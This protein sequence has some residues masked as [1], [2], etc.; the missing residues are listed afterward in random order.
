MQLKE[1]FDQLVLKL[2]PV[3]KRILFESVPDLSDNTLA[4]FNEMISRELNE[5]YELCWLIRSKDAKLPHNNN[6]TSINPKNRLKYAFFKRTSCAVICCNAMIEPVRNNQKTFFLTHGVPVKNVKSYNGVDAS[7]MDYLITPSEKLNK[8]MSDQLNID[9]SRCIAC[10]FPRNDVFYSKP[11]SLKDYFDKDYKKYIVWYPT[12]R[13]SKSGRVT[14]SKD[15]MP[16]LHDEN[17]AVELNEWAKKYDVLLIVKPH[18]AQNTDY[19]KKLDLS[20]IRLIDDTFFVDNRIS[21]YEFL[22]ACDS[23]ITDYSSVY[24]DYLLADKPIAVVWEDIEEYRKNPGFAIDIDYYMKAAFKI[25]DLD[26]FKEYIKIL[27]EKK[28]YLQKERS[29]ILL[30]S[31]MA[32]QGVSSGRLVDFILSVIEK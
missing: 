9:I 31:G 29:E 1:Y 10:G 12:Y 4:V 6:V 24:F 15:S 23:M 20:N 3:K 25:Y 18:F 16:I 13:Q 30:E 5:K 8:L 32:D 27:S 22:N 11:L 14:G 26:D 7:K 2:I 28:D 21:S 19:I 17:V